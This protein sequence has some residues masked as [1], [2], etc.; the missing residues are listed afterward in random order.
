MIFSEIQLMCEMYTY[1]NAKFPDVV[2]LSLWGSSHLAKYF[3]C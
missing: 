1:V 3:T 2:V